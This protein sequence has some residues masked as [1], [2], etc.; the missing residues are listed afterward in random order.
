MKK[1]NHKKIRDGVTN[2]QISNN[3]LTSGLVEQKKHC[4]GWSVGNVNDANY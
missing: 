4:M 2:T 3:L 1:K